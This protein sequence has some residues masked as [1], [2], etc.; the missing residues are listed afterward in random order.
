[1]MIEKIGM[2]REIEKLFLSFSSQ[3]SKFLSILGNIVLLHFNIHQAIKQKKPLKSGLLRRVLPFSWMNGFFKIFSSNGLLNCIRCRL[4]FLTVSLFP[5]LT[6]MF[7]SYLID[8][9]Y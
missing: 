5:L 4:S 7:T 1:M 8:Y 3:S 6:H 9:I 2:I